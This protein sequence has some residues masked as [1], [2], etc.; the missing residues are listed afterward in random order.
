MSCGRSFGVCGDGFSSTFE[1]CDLGADGTLN[2]VDSLFAEEYV[3]N[4]FGD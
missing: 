4:V 3:E 2:G 1:Q